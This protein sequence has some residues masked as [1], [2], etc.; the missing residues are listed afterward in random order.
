MKN[1]SVV[2]ETLHDAKNLALILTNENLCCVGLFGPRQSMTREEV[3]PQ[4]QTRRATRPINAVTTES[5]LGPV[6][7]IEDEEATELDPG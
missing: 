2:K 4:V 5:V 7:D 3:M 6:V 1:I